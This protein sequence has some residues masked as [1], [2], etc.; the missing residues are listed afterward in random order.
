MRV[1]APARGSD[2]PLIAT[3]TLS[4]WCLPIYSGQV[5][6]RA[7]GLADTEGNERKAS[8]RHI[9]IEDGLVCF[10]VEHA[11]LGLAAIVRDAPTRC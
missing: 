7:T 10:R 3:G 5:V 8:P 9:E 11:W 6:Q 4:M 2:S 1:H